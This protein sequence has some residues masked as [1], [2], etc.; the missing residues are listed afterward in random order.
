MASPVSSVRT[1][2]D[3]NGNPCSD[4]TGCLCSEDGKTGCF[5]GGGILTVTETFSFTSAAAREAMV[6]SVDAMIAGYAT[7]G[8]IHPAFYTKANFNVGC[9]QMEETSGQVGYKSTGSI[10]GD[11]NERTLIGLNGFMTDG[12]SLPSPCIP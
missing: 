5:A 1:R 12:F 11:G 3:C 10:D 8:K 9:E 6:S 2:Q 4:P 7:V